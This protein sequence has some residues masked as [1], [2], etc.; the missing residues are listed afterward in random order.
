M[1]RDELDKIDRLLDAIDHPECYSPE[2]IEAIANDRDTSELY[3]QLCKTRSASFAGN[4]L[5]ESEVDHQWERFEMRNRRR[6]SVFGKLGRRA[7]IWTAVAV[8]SCSVLA[9]GISVGIR[10]SSPQSQVEANLMPG[11]TT[12]TS[13]TTP[14][15]VDTLTMKVETEPILFDGETLQTILG[16]MAPHY[17]VEVVYGNETSKNIKLYYKWDPA[18]PVEAVIGE[19]NTFDRIRISLKGD[20]LKIN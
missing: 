11:D 9:V 14:A 20:T 8:A 19:F 12:I 2:E 13:I 15:I 4:S 18:V 7:A 5:T 3:A 17:G 10:K 1:I 16:R 6:V